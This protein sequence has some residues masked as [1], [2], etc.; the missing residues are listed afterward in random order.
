MNIGRLSL[1][2][3]IAAQH[4]LVKVLA[5]AVNVSHGELILE[6]AARHGRVLCARL[7]TV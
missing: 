6:K 5:V 7:V 2:V 4:T 3:S 1:E